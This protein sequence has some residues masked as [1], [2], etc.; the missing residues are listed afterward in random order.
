M[1]S[2]NAHCDLMAK[3]VRTHTVRARIA[4]LAVLAVMVV[5]GR[6]ASALNINLEFDTDAN[7]TAAGLSAADITAMKAACASAAAQ[8]TSRYSDPINVNIK[9]TASPGTSDLGSSTTPF[10]TVDSYNNLRA[11]FAA[12]S[13]TA[14]DATTVGAG[15]S[16]PAGADPIATAHIY[17][18]T[19]A[20]A[21]ALGLRPNDAQNDGTF[22]FGGG[23][24]W[25]YDPNNRNVAGKFDFIGVAMH[26]YSEI[27][28]RN[29]LM[30]D[31][32]GT[33]TPQ[34]VA[35]DL[36]HY[37]GPGARGF[38]K[39][40]GRFFSFNNGTNLLIAFNDNTA[41]GG[42]LQDWAGPAPDSFNA[43]GPPGEQDDLTPVDLQNMDVIGY[44]RGT[45][46]TPPGSAANISTRL[47][48]GTGDSLL[49]TGF[50]ITG[51]GGSTKKVIVRG[52]GPS[53]NVPGA[54][55]NPTLELHDN[56]G[57]LIAS[58]DNWKTTVIGGIITSDQVADIQASTV[59]PTNDA[60]S[61]L[62][63]TLAP[64]SYT[65]QVRGAN[66]TTGIGVA[67]AFDLSLGSAAKLANVSTRGQV[68]AGDNLMIAGFIIVNN[69]L[70]VVVRG[71]GPS[72]TA[73]GVPGVLADPTLELRDGNGALVL[74]NNDWKLTQ[75]AEIRA[76]TL[77]PSNDLEAAL[78]ITLQP[79]PYTAQLRGNNSGTGIGV[80][81]VFALP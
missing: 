29:S 63:G 36:F 74:G 76:T 26:E 38:G 18:V 16:L 5:A 50:I 53:T 44:D 62:I 28:G 61:A 40:P 24:K 14:D 12:D 31:A 45:T 49:I 32:L 55:A 54:L 51:P 27:M 11:A 30:G 70:K 69:P 65:A 8:F 10:D 57:A 33:G 34:Y 1:K 17:N 20:Q 77:Q 56:S 35:M 71:I 9:V 6:T 78:V 7:Y 59:A 3:P 22:N 79:G 52:T 81:D 75:E 42:D 66:N 68:G 25:T 64:G 43:A 23:Q 67:E 48:V 46:T 19:R 73:F 13:K 15:G 2:G 47:P 80:V 37:T 21:K 58:N 4:L 72:L 39:G 60:E 41:N